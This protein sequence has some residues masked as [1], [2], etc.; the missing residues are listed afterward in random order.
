MT[1]QVKN[2]TDTLAWATSHKKEYAAESGQSMNIGVIIFGVI[3][4]GFF[5]WW[6]LSFFFSASSET[7]GDSE[8]G[9]GEETEEEGEPIILEPLSKKT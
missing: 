6:F 1:A 2:F 4:F 9:E 8:E 5:A 3:V 7:E